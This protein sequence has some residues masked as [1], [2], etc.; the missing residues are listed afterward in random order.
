MKKVKRITLHYG[1]NH[2]D[3]T[4]QLAGKSLRIELSDGSE[5]EI[6]LYE[7]NKPVLAIRGTSCALAIHPSCSNSIMIECV[8]F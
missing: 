7:R 2:E 1:L 3:I 4:E 8:K 6:E 5:L